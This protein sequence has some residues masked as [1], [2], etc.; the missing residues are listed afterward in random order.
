MPQADGWTREVRHSPYSTARHASY[1]MAQRPPAVGCGCGCGVQV[2]RHG[3][4]FERQAE[5]VTDAIRGAALELAG[6]DTQVQTRSAP[7]RKADGR[8]R[9]SRGTLGR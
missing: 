8:F 5:L 4:L 9:S 6:Y 3:I 1:G 7:T 2:L